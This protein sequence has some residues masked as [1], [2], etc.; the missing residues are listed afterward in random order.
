LFQKSFTNIDRGSYIQEVLSR[1]Y[2]TEEMATENIDNYRVNEVIRELYNKVP[3]PTFEGKVVVLKTA[4]KNTDMMQGYESYKKSQVLTFIQFFAG[5]IALLLSILIY[6]KTKIKEAFEVGKPF[7]FYNKIPIDGKLFAFVVSAYLTYIFLPDIFI[8]FDGFRS[9]L[10]NGYLVQRIIGQLF[11]F[12]IPSILLVL[13]FIQGKWLIDTLKQTEDI[14]AEWENSYTKKGITIA[15]EMFINKSIGVQSLMLLG[16]IFLGGVGAVSIVTPLILIYIPLFVFILVPAVLIFLKRIGYFNKIVKAADNIANGQFQQDIPVKGK[17]PFAQLARNINKMKNNVST[18]QQQQVK[19]ERLK[20]ELISNVSHDLRTPLTSIITYTDLLKSGKLT[21]DE[22]KAY[23]EIIDRKSQR[24]KILIDDLFEASKMATGN[25]E[26]QK[27]R[28]DI[29]Q[30]LKQ[31]LAELN[32]QIDESH[33]QFRTTIKDEPIY[34]VVDGRKVW[35]V[36]DNLLNNILKYSLES[37]RVYII[38]EKLQN[39]AVVTFKN[40]SK[41][42]LGMDTDELVERFKRGDTSRHTEGSGLGLAIAKSIIDLH[43]GSLIID[44]NGDLFT[45]TVTLPAV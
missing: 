13:T 30:L 26:L 20:T 5:I 39:N 25:I 33:L 32:E 24:L 1:S 11:D 14:Q 16:I 15:Q 2:E 36:F 38:A 37:S 41:Y 35:R 19:S 3:L 40:I 23:I 7:E 8:F 4:S 45:V 22:Q 34:A 6:R 21:E 44:T 10:E 9:A 27:E 43:G 42:E 12:L 28:V 17:S 31:S 18:S 29:V